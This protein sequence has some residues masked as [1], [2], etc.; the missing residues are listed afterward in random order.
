MLRRM[1]L[2]S[3]CTDSSSRS[4][5]LSSIDLGGDSTSPPDTSAN[6]QCAPARIMWRGST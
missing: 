4:G 1:P 2:Q 6:T 5:L 3:T